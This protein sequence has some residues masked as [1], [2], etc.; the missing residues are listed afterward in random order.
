MAA[1]YVLV[2]L[3]ANAA[4]LASAVLPSLRGWYSRRFEWVYCAAA[5][6]DM[7]HMSLIEL[8]MFSPRVRAVLMGPQWGDLSL[9]LDYSWVVGLEHLVAGSLLLSFASRGMFGPCRSSANEFVLAA[10][11]LLFCGSLLWSPALRPHMFRSP[12]LAAQMGLVAISAA[13]ARVTDV[14]LR[15]L[16][17]GAGLEKGGAGVGR[18]GKGEEG[19]VRES[20]SC[21]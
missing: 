3:P 14:R 9:G 19:R 6:S 10:R 15:A 4:L 17:A 20:R 2:R 12:H 18:G 1:T 21:A 13:M 8:V 16:C 11:A 7:L 5:L